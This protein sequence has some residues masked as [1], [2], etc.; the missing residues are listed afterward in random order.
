MFR[1]A[2]LFAFI[3]STS[4]AHTVTCNTREVIIKQLAERYGEVRIG[5]MTGALDGVIAEFWVNSQTG[6]WSLTSIDVNGKMCIFANGKN[7]ESLDEGL[8]KIGE[9]V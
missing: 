1:L 5:I 4:L 7:Y 9:R 3:A 6:T 2:V 8:I